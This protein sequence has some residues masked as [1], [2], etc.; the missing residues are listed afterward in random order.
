MSKLVIANWKMNGTKELLQSYL[1]KAMAVN[2]MDRANVVL[3]APNLYLASLATSGK[4]YKFKLSAQ[5]VSK[6]DDFGAYTGDINAAMLV[7]Y[8][9]SYCLIGHSERRQ[10]YG[11]GDDVVLAKLNNCFKHNLVPILCVGENITY[12]QNGNYLEFIAQQLQVIKSLNLNKL[13]KLI[14]AYEPIWAIGTGLVATQQDISEVVA[15]IKAWLAD[16]A[17]S[18]TS[19][20]IYGGSVNIKNVDSIMNIAN[21]DGVLVGGASLDFDQF[22]YICKAADTDLGC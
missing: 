11:E 6:F 21:I 2:Y 15:M 14:I 5:D 1:D 19:R 20:V 18:I 7:D 8:N 13:S 16:T 17:P 9:I 10:Y 4:P 12:R 22:D 3:A